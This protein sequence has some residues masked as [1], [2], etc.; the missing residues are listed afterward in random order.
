MA[1]LSLQGGQEA[2]L[3]PILRGLG[4][5]LDDPIQRLAWIHAQTLPA[6]AAASP[7]SAA[8]ACC[9]IA[10]VPGPARPVYLHGARLSYC[11][12][13][14]PIC[15][16]MGL[17]FAVT[18][19]DDR[20]VVSPTSCRELIP[21]P[22]AFTQCLRDSFQEYLTLALSQRPQLPLKRAALRRSTSGKPRPTAL[23]PRSDAK[24]LP[25]AKAGRRRS[26]APPR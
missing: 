5:H 23:A 4:T 2:T 7:A 3:P 21:D 19:Y 6:S 18:A 22:Q 9:T 16:G 10:H 25:A 12:A 13:I 17:V 11:S 15:D 14:L 20:I 8:L 1:A 24:P 26:T